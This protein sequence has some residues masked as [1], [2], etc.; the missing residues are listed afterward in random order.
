VVEVIL[1]KLLEVGSV[2]GCPK[3]ERFIRFIASRRS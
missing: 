1:P 2:V 3:V